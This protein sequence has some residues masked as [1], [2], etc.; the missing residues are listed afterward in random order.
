M[1]SEPASQA[2]AELKVV[3]SYLAIPPGQYRA[4]HSPIRLVVGT[5]DVT[6]TGEFL[7]RTP[8]LI[9]D[10]AKVRIRILSRISTSLG[11]KARLA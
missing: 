6:A 2:S 9:N 3:A 4:K 7:L 1:P 10:F 5:T 8:F 11:D